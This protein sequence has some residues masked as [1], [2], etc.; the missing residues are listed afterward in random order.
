METPRW[1]S[2]LTKEVRSSRGVQPSPD[3]GGGACPFEHF[4][5]VPGVERRAEVA[6]EY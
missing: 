2:R 3:P 4:P 6:G 1:L 5:D